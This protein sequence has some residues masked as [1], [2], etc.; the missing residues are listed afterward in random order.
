MTTS[1]FD[2]ASNTGFRHLVNATRFSLRGF[3]AAFRHESAF[4]QETAGLIVIVPAA[5]WLGDDAVQVAMLLGVYLLVFVVELLNSGIEAAVDHTSTEQHD[6][7]G[8]P[9]D[10]GSA[11]VFGAL[12]IFGLVWGAVMLE[13]FG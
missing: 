5:V 1:D 3:R 8:R 11:A 12:V 13:R 4:R 10:L 2:K 7:A 9:K 6:L